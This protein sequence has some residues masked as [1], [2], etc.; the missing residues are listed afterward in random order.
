MTRTSTWEIAWRQ[1]T[2][3]W[4]LSLSEVSLTQTNCSLKVG[5][6]CIANSLFLLTPAGQK[7]SVDSNVQ[8][9]TQFSSSL[10]FLLTHY[11]PSS[12]LLTSPSSVA[13]SLSLSPSLCAVLAVWWVGGGGCGWQAASTRRPSALQLLSHPQWVLERPGGKGL[14]Q[15]SFHTQHMFLGCNVWDH[16]LLFC[17]CYVANRDSHFSHLPYVG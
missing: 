7:K 15:V 13:V 14:C 10:Q 5:V 3:V 2:V 16:P 8:V 1:N 17:L 4:S 9:L 12:S 6:L 11:I